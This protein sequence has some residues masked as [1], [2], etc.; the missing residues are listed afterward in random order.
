MGQSGVLL[1]VL[2]SVSCRREQELSRFH[3]YL[4]DT[5][6]PS[7]FSKQPYPLHWFVQP[8]YVSVIDCLLLF[9]KTNTH[10]MVLTNIICWFYRSSSTRRKIDCTCSQRIANFTRKSAATGKI[11]RCCRI[12]MLLPTDGT[13]DF[14]RIR[15]PLINACC[16]PKRQQIALRAR[17]K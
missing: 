12:N 10:T 16:N 1:R 13:G 2:S 6:T 9:S 11:G 15:K 3:L 4:T 17:D 5:A 8:I 14:K 7:V